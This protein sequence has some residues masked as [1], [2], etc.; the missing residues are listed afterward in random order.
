MGKAEGNVKIVA[1]NR[2]ARHDFVIEDTYEAG[3]VL[4][5]SEVK[6]L[7]DGTCSIAEAYARPRGDELF[8]YDMHI[9]PY[10]QAN[11]N[12]HE[13]L[14]PRKLLLHRRE[15]KSVISQCAQRGRTLI[16]LAVYFKEGRAKVEIAVAQRRRKGDDRDKKL[17]RQE[18]K[19]AQRELGRGP[20]R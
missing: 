8:L 4:L 15:I 12:N 11:I 7:R 5:G 13:E 19:D 17:A 18:R 9:P 16:A 1:K 10:K 20:R 14:R 3:M 6:S 2:K